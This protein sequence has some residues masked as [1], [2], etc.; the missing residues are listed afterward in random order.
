MLMYAAQEEA[1]ALARSRI[2]TRHRRCLWSV[3]GPSSSCNS[4]QQWQRGHAP[5][6]RPHAA[7]RSVT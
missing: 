4:L 5:P 3:A 6:A 1:A 2:S 7:G